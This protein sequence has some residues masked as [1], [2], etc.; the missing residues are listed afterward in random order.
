VQGRQIHD[1]IGI[2]FEAINMLSKKVKEGNVTYKVDIHKAFDTLNWN[3]LVLKH[4][5]FHHSFFSWISTILRSTM[6]FV[7]FFPCSRGVRHDD[8]LSPLLFC[9]VDDVLS[10]GI[11]KLVNDNMILHMAS[12]KAYL[13]LSHILYV[14]DIFVFCRANNKSLKYLSIF[15][16]KYGDFSGQYV[17][18]SKSS[19]LTVDNSTRFITKIQ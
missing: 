11:S 3:F 7:K 18:N 13:T 19:F 4:F 14:D 17:N 15:L 1:C 8:L 12:P 9:L 16:R 6:L 2:A 10:R 5:G